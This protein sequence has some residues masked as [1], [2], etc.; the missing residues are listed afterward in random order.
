MPHTRAAH[1]LSKDLPP[2]DP[3]VF[4]SMWNMF[5]HIGKFWQNMDDPEPYRQNLYTFMENR[6]S[7]RPI[8][9]EYYAMARR[10]TDE[11]IASMGEDQA[12]AYLFTD[13]GAAQQPPETPLAVTRQKV[14]N[15]FMALQLSVGGFKVWGATNLPSYIGGANIPGQPAPYRTF[16]GA[17]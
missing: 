16:E 2:P 6:I 17:Q 7:L 9:H 12:Y 1:P 8:Y 5:V 14:A 11:L 13:A 15:E 4:A 3:Q 10:V